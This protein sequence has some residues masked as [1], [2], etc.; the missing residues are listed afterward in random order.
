M[1]IL[2]A[3]PP[4]ALCPT[5]RREVRA[6]LMR[7][8][9]SVRVRAAAA[10]ACSLATIA[11]LGAASSP[12]WAEEE[13]VLNLYNW[14]DYIGETTVREFEKETGIKVHYD[15]FDANE[16]LYAKLVAGRTGYD[17]V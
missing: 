11:A 8:N 4:L 16:T 7:M 1:T 14:A 12:A 17:V 9:I 2:R 6:P 10:A 5:G 3:P 13:K 15:T